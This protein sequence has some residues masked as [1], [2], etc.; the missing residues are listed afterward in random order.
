VEELPELSRGT[1]TEDLLQIRSIG[2]RIYG[3]DQQNEE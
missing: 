2:K 1:V 3:T